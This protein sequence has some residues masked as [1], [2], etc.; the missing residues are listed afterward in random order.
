M[1]DF[2]SGLT[3]LPWF[4]RATGVALLVSLGAGGRLGLALGARPGTGCLMLLS[5]NDHVKWPHCDQAQP[6]PGLE[7]RGPRSVVGPGELGQSECVV[8]WHRIVDR[9]PTPWL[10]STRHRT[11]TVLE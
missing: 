9:T 1:L 3:S 8:F 5:G 4:V 10:S 11:A 7:L 2:D 6:F